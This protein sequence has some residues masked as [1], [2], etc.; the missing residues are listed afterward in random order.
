[1]VTVVRE[2]TAPAPVR[3]A[4]VGWV[5][6]G[7]AA[8]AIAAVAIAAVAV[9]SQ[10]PGAGP[11]IERRTASL[12]TQDELA[13]VRLVQQGVIPRETLEGEPFRTKALVNQGLI[14]RGAVE[15]GIPLAGPLYCPEERALM[16][17]VAAGLVPEEALDYERLSVKRLVNQGLVPRAAAA[18]CR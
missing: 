18:P 10:R 3:G 16:R 6:G 1:M 9:L 4:R 7:F 8:I 13:V 11:V 15:A 17:A 5:L 12:Y 14:P 2:R